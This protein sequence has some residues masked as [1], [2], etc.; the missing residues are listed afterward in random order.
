MVEGR[1]GNWFEYIPKLKRRLGINWEII[2]WKWTTITLAS[3]RLPSV[4][5]S[6]RVKKKTFKFRHKPMQRQRYALEYGAGKIS[7]LM[8][9]G[10]DDSG[11]IFRRVAVAKERPFASYNTRYYVSW[12]ST[13]CFPIA[14]HTT[15]KF[16]P[17][18]EL[19]FMLAITVRLSL[20]LFPLF[21]SLSNWFFHSYERLCFRHIEICC[22]WLFN[23]NFVYGQLWT[24]SIFISEFSCL[25]GG[26]L[27]LLLLLLLLLNVH[28]AINLCSCWDKPFST[29]HCCEFFV[30][31][32]P[33]R[34]CVIFLLSFSAEILLHNKESALQRPLAIICLISHGMI[35]EL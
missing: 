33:L 35:L 11:T 12:V 23:A 24:M 9:I 27:L 34:V 6:E 32:R 4:R 5:D 28:I 20:F 3:T 22:K 17:I 10:H 26:S 25:F 14:W 15:R 21:T 30:L 1:W 19:Q 7:N 13:S 8:Y 31:I 29:V 16:Y 2:E 18:Y